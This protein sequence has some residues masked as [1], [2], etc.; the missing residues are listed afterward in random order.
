V[1]LCKDCRHYRLTFWQRI[2]GRKPLCDATK[3]MSPVDG[4]VAFISFCSSERIEGC[5]RDAK[6]F[7][8]KGKV[9]PPFPWPPAPRIVRDGEIPPLPPAPTWACSTLTPVKPK[10]ARKKRS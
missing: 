6:N 5:G 7:E 4:K 3:V 10:R 2:R 8:H 9:S 1:K